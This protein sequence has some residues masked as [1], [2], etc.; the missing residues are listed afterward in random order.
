[1][2]VT[3]CDGKSSEICSNNTDNAMEAWTVTV[4]TRDGHVLT[5][6][7]VVSLVQRTI[8]SST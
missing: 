5:L 6:T 3:N 1:V 7:P 8:W 4:L 2:S